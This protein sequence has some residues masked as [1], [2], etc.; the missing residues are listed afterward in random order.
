MEWDRKIP[1]RLNRL[2]IPIASHLT[3]QVGQAEAHRRLRFAMIFLLDGH[4]SFVRHW[5]LDKMSASVGVGGRLITR[6]NYMSDWFQ[7]LNRDLEWA[8]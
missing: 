6:K 2:G 3:G 1:S 8:L 5:R 4:L 7:T